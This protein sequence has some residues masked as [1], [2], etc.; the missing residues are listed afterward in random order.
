M[1]KL[2]ISL[3]VACFIFIGGVA[4]A[5][6]ESFGAYALTGGT[7]GCLDAINGS[8]LSDSDVCTVRMLTGTYFY[9]LD[10]DSAADEASPSIISPDTNAGDKRW[11]LAEVKPTASTTVDG[12]AELATEAEAIAG[13]D[14][15]RVVTPDALAYVLQ[16]GTMTYVS[17]AGS[18]DTYVA[19][20]VPAV[21]ALETGMQAT[22]R[23][24]TANTRAATLNVNGLGA[25]AIKK[26]YDQDLETG[27]IETG[28]QVTFRYRDNVWE[29][30]SQT[31][32]NPVKYDEAL[33]ASGTYDGKTVDGVMGATVT[34]GDL[35][36]L[37]TSDQRWELTDADA[38]ATAGDVMLGIVIIGGDDGDTGLLL[39]EGFIRNDDWN[40]TSYG[41]C[42]F[43]SVTAGDMSQTAVA[44]DTDIHRVVG[45]AHDN[46]DTIYFRPDNLWVELDI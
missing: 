29:M 32:R 21:A 35:V 33:S 23:A 19:T 6:V 45:Y 2:L 10:A 27:D 36:Y 20:Y 37:A 40:F 15:A 34:F 43:I 31:A 25:L 7:S 44:G 12:T 3:F 28:Q 41:Q 24:N 17:D 8:L 46:A 11:I 16:R 5:T 13:T 18:T 30:Q 1:K 14:A 42:L 4:N 22:F 26:H 38:E 39:L 9:V